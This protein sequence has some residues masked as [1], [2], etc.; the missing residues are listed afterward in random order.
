VASKTVPLS[1]PGHQAQNSLPQP[2]SGP[3]T[4][5][6]TADIVESLLAKSLAKDDLLG[7]LYASLVVA[8]IRRGGRR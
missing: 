3:T 5:K 4:R 6:R 2:D 1:F 7:R 8:R